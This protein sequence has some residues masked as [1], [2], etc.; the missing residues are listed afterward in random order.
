MAN[1]PVYKRED[2]ADRD[3]KFAFVNPRNTSTLIPSDFVLEDVPARTLVVDGCSGSSYMMVLSQRLMAAHGV[4]VH[5]VGEGGSHKA[6]LVR[7]MAS[8][9]NNS[10]KREI[11][12]LDMTE[13]L[14]LALEAARRNNETMFFKTNTELAKWDPTWYR[15][16]AFFRNNGVKSALVF[17]RNILDWNVCRVR[18]CFDNGNR[19]YPVDENGEL[20]QACFAR[21]DDPN[22]T[23]YAYMRT[24]RLVAKMQQDEVDRN[25]TLRKL[26]DLGLVTEAVYS[27]DLLSFERRSH[28][29]DLSTQGW[30]KILE[31]WGINASWA[32]I[33]KVLANEPLVGKLPEPGPHSQVIWNIEKVSQKLRENGLAK[34]LRT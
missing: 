16:G 12:D 15:K 4:M 5:A 7:K 20:N 26:S 28:G 13:S 25:E 22:L 10:E 34:Y 17:R 31:S 14:K 21:R 27:E 24:E 29:L 33:Q 9:F 6:D 11:E 23:T 32:I 19:G 1:D 8:I 2:Y 3:W 18:D 30:K